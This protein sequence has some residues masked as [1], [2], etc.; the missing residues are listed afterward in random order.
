LILGN[1][2]LLAY[3][4]LA[5]L[6]FHV[7][8]LLYEEPT[9]RARFGAKYRSYCAAVPRWIPRIRGCATGSAC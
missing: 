6:L 7:F 5:W 3:A 1:V 2:T 8:V 4:G 9:L